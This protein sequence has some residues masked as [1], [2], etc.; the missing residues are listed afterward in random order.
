M[1]ESDFNDALGLLGKQVTVKLGEED[2]A[3][4]VVRGQLLALG[5]FGEF[6]VRDDNDQLHYCW[7]MLHIEEA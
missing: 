2:G 4:V 5:T 7:P 6:V 3:P 1:T